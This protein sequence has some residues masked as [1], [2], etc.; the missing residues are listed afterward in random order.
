MGLELTNE[1]LCQET[2]MPLPLSFLSG[3][4]YIINFDILI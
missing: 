1:C 3:N 4:N 2:K